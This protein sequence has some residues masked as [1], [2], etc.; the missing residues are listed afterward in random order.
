[1]KYAVIDISGHQSFVTENETITIDKIDGKPDEKL[2]T[3]KVLLIVDNNKVSLGT[4]YIKN[5]LV[6]YQ[7]IKHYQGTK[8]KVF[9]YKAKSRYRK[10]MGFRPQLTDIKI[11][12]IGLK[13]AK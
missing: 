13:K 6:S 8:L 5:T 11:T 1:M 3:D 2:D 12:K 7:V 4:P 9:K 10:T